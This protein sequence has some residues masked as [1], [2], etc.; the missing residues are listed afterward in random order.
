MNRY[1][2]IFITDGEFAAQ[3]VMADDI[4]KAINAFFALNMQY[5]E[6]YSISRAA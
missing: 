2:V 5:E 3:T 6:I 4:F 1:L